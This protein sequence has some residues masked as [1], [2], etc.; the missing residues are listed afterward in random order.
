MSSICD[1]GYTRMFKICPCG[2]MAKC[3]AQKA[4]YSCNKE[5]ISARPSNGDGRGRLTKRCG[6]CH[7]MAPSNRTSVC[8]CGVR[9]PTR[10]RAPRNERQVLLRQVEP[11]ENHEVQESMV[12]QIRFQSSNQDVVDVLMHEPLL[13]EENN[14]AQD[15]VVPE[16]GLDHFW[17]FEH[18]FDQSIVDAKSSFSFRS[19]E[20]VSV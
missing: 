6:S 4:C 11:Q 20:G 19:R 9:F 13:F 14:D 12:P 2:V 5:F 10:P 15:F 16:D 7:T 8:A 18:F 1:S 3:N 17:E